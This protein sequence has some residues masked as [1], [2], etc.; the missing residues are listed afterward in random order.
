MNGNFLLPLPRMQRHRQ[1]AVVQIQFLPAGVESVALGIDQ[2][3]ALHGDPVQTK[4]PAIFR[5]VKAQ[6]IQPPAAAS[7]VENKLRVTA[8]QAL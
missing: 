5:R 6:G 4:T 3:I 1:P 2:T 7:L 8:H